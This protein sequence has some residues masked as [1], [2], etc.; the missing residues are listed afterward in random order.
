MKRH[1]R[2]LPLMFLMFLAGCQNMPQLFWPADDDK[3]DYARSTGGVTGRAESRAPLD[4][5]PELRKEIEVPMPD[6]VATGTAMPEQAR[7]LIAGKA[8]R[9]DARLYPRK[10]AQVFSA[11]VDAMTALNLPVESVDSPSGTITTTWIHPN[12]NS[13][14]SYFG[15]MMNI[16][17]AGPVATR[18]RYVVRVLRAKGGQTMLQVRT[19]GQQFINRHW[20]NK[21]LKKKLANDLFSAVEE[22]LGALPPE[23]Q[24]EPQLPA[25]PAMPRPASP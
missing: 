2:F 15:A 11:V 21:P 8:V 4:V 18:Y 7:K 25:P 5:P 17:G 13:V 10:P 19:L 23:T 24:P 6:Q 20:V 3:P 1:A 16:V 9:L 14:N 22:R 12:A